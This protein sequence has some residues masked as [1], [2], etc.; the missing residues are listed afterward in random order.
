MRRYCLI[1]GCFGLLLVCDCGAARNRTE[2]AMKPAPQYALG[3]VFH[4]A[5]HNGVRDPGEAGL[6]RVRV[7]NGCRI[8]RTDA[9]GRYRLPIDDDTILFV[10]KP[11]GWMTLVNDDNLPRFYYVH[12]PG[13][14]DDL[15]HPGVAPTGPLPDSVDFA[16]VRHPE[17]GQF[18]AVFLGDPQPYAQKEIDYLAHDVVEELIGTDAMFGVT[19]GDIVGDDL[20]LLDSINRTIGLIGVPWYS[21]LGNHD[22]NQDSPDDPRSDETFERVFGP[23]YYSFD[24]GRVHFLVLDDV[25]WTGATDGTEA[26]Y[27]GGL[28]PEQLRFIRN[29][30]AL[31]PANRLVVL[32]MHIPLLTPEGS[33]PLFRPADREALFGILEKHPHTLSLSAHWHMQQ[34][35]FFGRA[36]GWNGPEPH[37][38]LICATACGSWWKGAP[39]EAGIPHTTMRDGAPNGYSIITFD[40]HR[41]SIVFKAARRPADHQMTIFAP[42]EVAAGNTAQAEVFVN[43]FAGSQRSRVEMRLGRQGPW[44]AMRRI[45]AEDPYYAAMKEAEQSPRPPAGRALPDAENCPHLWQVPLPADAPRGTHLIHVRTTD[46]FGQ[47]YTAHRVIRIR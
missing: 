26:S 13:G 33:E 17:L 14:S 5:N 32:M 34:H 3:V 24:Y 16:L 43:V 19:L 4:D 31:V 35:C 27:I 18:G 25:I 37:H 44:I 2:L 1:A 47:T 6:G 28:D 9:Q 22:L 10:I 45:E 23:A 15:K 30:L 42:E 29:D 38:H 46:M 20:S 21:V 11:S 36:D 40:G 12:K 8:V 41:Y 39:D 7:S